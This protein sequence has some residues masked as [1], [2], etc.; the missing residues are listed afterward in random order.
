MLMDKVVPLVL[1][2][3]LLTGTSFKDNH[4]FVGVTDLGRNIQPQSPKLQDT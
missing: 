3:N 1:F 4:N 2:P